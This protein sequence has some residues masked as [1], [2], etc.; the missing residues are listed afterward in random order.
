MLFRSLMVKPQFEVGRE[1]LGSGGVVRD[2]ALH[3]E[4]V[5]TVAAAAVAQGLGVLRVSAS[6]LPGPSG[7]V[8]YFLWLRRGAP[9]LR[10]QDLERAIAEGP[11]G[12]GGERKA[13]GAGGVDGVGGTVGA[14]AVDGTVGAGGVAGAAVREENG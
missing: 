8:E 12:T 11:A 2:P 1:R 5:R 13:V 4:S 10:E 14:G 7:N 3:A 9:A 6:P